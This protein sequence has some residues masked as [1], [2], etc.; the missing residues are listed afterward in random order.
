[1]S[2]LIPVLVLS[3]GCAH[4]HSASLD[5]S[6]KS[7][8]QTYLKSSPPSEWDRTTRYVR[9]FFDL[10]G[11]GNPEAI[12]YVSGRGW[13]GT[14]GCVMLILRRNGSSFKVVA[15]TTITRPP[16]RV[17]ETTSRGW[18]DVGSNSGELLYP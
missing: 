5:E 8:L 14:G 7:F 16:I 6:L 4:L 3:I 13:C 15:R 17:L 11:D 10:D 18:R 2:R 1:M 9:A 12:V